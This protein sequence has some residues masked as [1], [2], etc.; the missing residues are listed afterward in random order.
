MDFR[1]VIRN[2]TG[3]YINIPVDIARALEIKGGERL[4]VS[5]VT[6]IGIFITQ[7]VG[8]DRTPIKPKSIEGLQKAADFI[9]SQAEMKLK[10]L[11]ANSVSS[12]YT[13]MIANISRL[14]IFKIQREVDGLLKREEKANQ[15]KGKL[16]LV[17][18]RKKSP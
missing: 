15:E 2:K 10:N 6:G 14:G 12:Y 13:S 7:A 11:E 3:F 1:K 5:Y 18:Q 16:T 17:R 8:S 4:R 9:I